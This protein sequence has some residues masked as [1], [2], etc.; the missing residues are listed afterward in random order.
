MDPPHFLLP[1]G[2]TILQTGKGGKDMVEQDTVKLLRECD[3]GVKMGVSSI[4]D[5]LDYVHGEK[6]KRRL[7]DCKNEHENLEREIRELLDKYH[8]GG[9]TAVS[10][11]LLSNTIF[12]K[13]PSPSRSTRWKKASAPNCWTATAARFP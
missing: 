11:R 7:S 8:D 13:Q 6:L 12:P 9:K 3:A 10:L 5:V 4:E 2:H 1:G